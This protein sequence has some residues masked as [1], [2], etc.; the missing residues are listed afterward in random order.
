MNKLTK[1][2][3]FTRFLPEK[4]SK[5]PNFY[6]IFLKVNKILEFDMIFARKM[7]KF[8]IIIARKIFFQNFR[9]SHGPFAPPP[10]SPTSMTETS[11]TSSSEE[12][13]LFHSFQLNLLGG[14][15]RTLW[16]RLNDGLLVN[17]GIGSGRDSRQLL[18]TGGTQLT[19]NTTHHTQSD[20]AGATG[21]HRRRIWARCSTKDR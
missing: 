18:M 14:V 20:L 10:P 17:F 9:G 19:A 2:P 12:L 3:N 6:N 4:L 1:C 11:V 5:Y 16:P 15:D 7:P 8:Y 13:R 21:G